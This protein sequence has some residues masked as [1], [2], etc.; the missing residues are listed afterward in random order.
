M[1]KHK[2]NETIERLNKTKLVVPSKYEIL[3]E[4]RK[5]ENNADVKVKKQKLKIA[6]NL[7]V[8][9]LSARKIPDA[10]YGS[11]NHIVNP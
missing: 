7:R 6:S 10:K 2:I 8:R 9:I 5:M 1:L 3:G 4:K 11:I